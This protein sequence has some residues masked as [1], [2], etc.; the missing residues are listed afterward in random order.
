MDKY[1]QDDLNTADGVWNQ[2]PKEKNQLPFRSE[3]QKY[4]VKSSIF[5]DDSLI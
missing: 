3:T 5:G 4:V 2:S 1:Y